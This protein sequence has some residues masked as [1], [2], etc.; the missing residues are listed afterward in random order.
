MSKTVESSTYEAILKQSVKKPFG[1]FRL[2]K[3][4][5]AY[6]I[7]VLFLVISFFVR[8]FFE[9]QVTTD[10][11]SEFDKAK[12]SVMSRFDRKIQTDLVILQ[13]LQAIYY[14]YEQVV[15][16]YFD[17]YASLP[18]KTY[19]SI[20]SLYHAQYITPQQYDDFIFSVQRTGVYNYKIFPSGRRPYY[21][22]VEYIVPQSKNLSILGMDVAAQPIIYETMKI[23]CDSNRIVSTPVFEI[24]KDTLGF[25]FVAP[26]YK[27]DSSTKTLEDRRRNF[28]G[29]VII[30]TDA[31]QLF[32]EA[33]GEG[34][35]S[36]TS[37]LY[38]TI[39][40]DYSNKQ[41]SFYESKNYNLSK[42]DYKPFTDI[43]Y[44]QV[45]NRQFAVQF[46]TVP[47]FMT[48]FQ[49]I[50]PALSLIISLVLSFAFFG[51][52]LSVTTSRARA[53]DLAE[54][55]TRSQRRIVDS[56]KDIIAVMDYNG[57]WKSM[58]PAS[59]GIFSTTPA[60]MMFSKIDRLFADEADIKKFYQLLRDTN[61]EYTERVD[62]QMKSADGSMKWINWSFTVSPAD[63]LI[64]CIGRDVTLE[65]IAE[66]QT[67]L[68]SKQIQ[69]AEQ[70]AKEANEFKSYFMTKISHQLRNSLTGITGY[71]E[72][73][74]KKLFDNKEEE[75]S[76]FSLA[77]D[78]SEELYTFVSDIVEVAFSGKE[79]SFKELDTVDFKSSIDETIRKFR[80]S[81]QN[82]LDLK[83]EF[84]EGSENV[85]FVADKQLLV[86]S[87]NEVLV[88][89]TQ[90][91]DKCNLQ[92]GATSNDSEGATEIQILTDA[93]PL[94]S[95]MIELYKNNSTNLIEALKLDK[96]DI[97]LHF[98]TASS[99]F[100]M[101]SG[102]MTVDSFGANEGNLVQISLPKNVSFG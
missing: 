13:S 15:V 48:G 85:S 94:V 55:M 79:G 84:M 5:P 102:T 56:S 21:F 92:L 62:F 2:S 59:A 60:D 86:N 19:P 75:K 39:D 20:I 95:E 36:D 81:K 38:K 12:N 101:M 11:N 30:E 26:I 45:A 99:C 90:G 64:Y 40:N 87:L 4:Y 91:M 22:P 65:K 28:N 93:N 89:L 100:K 47:N 25:C 63:H 77:E 69:L 52:V 82:D 80:D 73:L 34:I 51:F 9:H 16:D 32:V 54:R 66:E 57:N 50:L 24:R 18:A 1:F 67:I 6:I 78:S 70:F 71:L 46:A 49:K 14:K 83:V 10:V 96:K 37:I 35:S 31:P 7:L 43:Q 44:L 3:T 53:V 27:K 98:A 58:N 74:S 17:L 41:T 23:A 68:K 88:S 42:T 72:L 29:V 76:Y 61:E 97:I 8:N 33:L